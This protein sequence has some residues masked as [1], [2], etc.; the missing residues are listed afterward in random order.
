MRKSITAQVERITPLT[1]SILQVVLKPAKYLDYQ[2][3]QYLQLLT[4]SGELSYSIANAPLGSHH[5]ELHI[6]HSQDNVANQQLLAEIKEKGE[7]KIGIP[8]GDCHLNKLSP[9]IPILFIAGGTGFAPIKAMIEQLLATNDKRSFEL[10]WGARSQ[11][12]LYMDE[13]VMQWQAH[14]EHFHYFSLLSNTSKETL[15]S[16]ILD[17]HAIDLKQ[18]QIVIAGPFDM[19]FAIRDILLAHDV[20]RAQLF[21]DAFAFEEIKGS[22]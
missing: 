9:N 13:K 4:Q 10:F 19:V 1:D 18:W 6:R 11:S 7:V 20:P 2:P 12:D 3:G 15:A 14:V 5:Y 22:E 17:H 21:S 16:V 8:R